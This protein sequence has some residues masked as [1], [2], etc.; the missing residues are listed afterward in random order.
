MSQE[1]PPPPHPIMLYGKKEFKKPW[2]SMLTV[3]SRFMLPMQQT[4]AKVCGLGPWTCRSM[5]RTD[6]L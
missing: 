3:K 4:R 1:A 2:R 5:V 6:M